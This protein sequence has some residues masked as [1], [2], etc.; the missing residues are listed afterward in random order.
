[1]ELLNAN[2]TY[3]HNKVIVLK[4]IIEA[5]RRVVDHDFTKENRNQTK[6]FMQ[7]SKGTEL[8]TQRTG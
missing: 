3:I 8:Q 5:G 1:M 6:P 7:H 2:P 4:Q